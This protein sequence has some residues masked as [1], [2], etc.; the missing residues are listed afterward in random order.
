MKGLKHPATAIAT[1]A[2]FVA[3]GGTVAV[4]S[5]VISGSKIKNHSIPE[6]KLTKSAITAL[7]GQQGPQGPQGE[8]GQQGSQGDTGATGPA[9]TARAWAHVGAD[10][11]VASQHNVTSVTHVG[12]GDYCVHLAGSIT[13]SSSVA[14]LTQSYLEDYTS[15]A[16]HR[17]ADVEYE[18]PC[19]SNGLEVLTLY[20]DLG[21]QT[22]VQADQG[23]VIVVP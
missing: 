12:A 6:K 21:S 3:L 20:A 23:F 7:Q 2:L 5:G 1:L 15:V 14:D 11:T 18:G 10:G 13:A 8:Q 16:N 22:V 17:L 4:A 19:T 9:G